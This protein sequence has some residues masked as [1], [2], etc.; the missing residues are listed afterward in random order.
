[1]ESKSNLEISCRLEDDA[2]SCEQQYGERE[3]TPH[4][5]RPATERRPPD[6]AQPRIFA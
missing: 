3:G 5:V 1:M 6:E 4:K 2:A